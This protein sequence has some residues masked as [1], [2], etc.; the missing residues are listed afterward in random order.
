M[1]CALFR[2]MKWLWLHCSKTSPSGKTTFLNTK[3]G[4]KSL[5]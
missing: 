5:I 4:A 1:N 2:L 3:Y